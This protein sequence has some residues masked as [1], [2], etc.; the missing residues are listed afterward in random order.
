[1][2]IQNSS[3]LKHQIASDTGVV[4]ESPQIIVIKDATSIYNASHNNIQATEIGELF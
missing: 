1:M 3:D 4:H 2:I